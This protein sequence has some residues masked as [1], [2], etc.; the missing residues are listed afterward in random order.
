M[1]FPEPE[2]LFDDYQGRGTAAKSAEMNILKD[3]NWAGDSKIRPEVMDELGIPGTLN[4]DQRAYNNNLGRM[5]STQ[6]AAW[7]AVY[8]PINE[9]FK[10]RYPSMSDEE[11]MRWRYQRYM[12]DYIATI[13]AVDDGVGRVLDYLEEHGLDENTI[14]VYTS[15]KSAAG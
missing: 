14:V 1:K 11:L 9:D 2:T 7:D 3:M 10:N 4:W 5:D 13:A 6:R 15:D 8:D 12:Q